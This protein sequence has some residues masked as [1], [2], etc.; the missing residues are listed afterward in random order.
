[1]PLGRKSPRVVGTSLVII[2]PRTTRN[3]ASVILLTLTLSSSI[4]AFVAWLLRTF[5]RRALVH[6]IVIL[7]ALP[8]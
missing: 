3:I 8:S 2:L 7:I 5:R 1:M 4:S 6:G